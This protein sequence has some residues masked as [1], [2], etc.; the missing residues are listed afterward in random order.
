MIHQISEFIGI[1]GVSGIFDISIFGF[2]YFD[3]VIKFIFGVWVSFS[4]VEDSDLSWFKFVHGSGSE[5][6]GK[7]ISSES[8]KWIKFFEEVDDTFTD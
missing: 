5:Y 2:N 7:D 3:I 1:V 6:G 4:F 8:V